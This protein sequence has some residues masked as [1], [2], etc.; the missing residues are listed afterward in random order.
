MPLPRVLAQ[1]VSI[2]EALR[3]YPGDMNKALE[4]LQGPLFDGLDVA[5]LLDELPAVLE[6]DKGFAELLG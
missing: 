6:A 3:E 2:A 5:S 4:T 1:A